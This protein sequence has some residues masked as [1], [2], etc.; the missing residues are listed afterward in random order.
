M[1]AAFEALSGVLKARSGLTLGPGKQ[2]L[3]ETRLAPVLRREA[4]A[5][6]AAL[7]E[8]VLAAIT[9]GTAMTTLN[10]GEAAGWFV[11]Q[12][13]DEAYVRSLR[14]RLVFPLVPFDDDL[15]IRAALLLPATRSAGLS[16]GDRAC[17][18]LAR[19]S[20]T[21]ALTA[22][23]AWAGASVG[24]VSAAASRAARKGRMGIL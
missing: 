1:S 15:A 3:L 20:G 14:A 8:R 19:R 18:A 21:T 13:A 4:L 23:R 2:Y 9:A 5:D 10:F 11:R 22:D 24:R 12:G 17:L 16:L 7:A 6:L